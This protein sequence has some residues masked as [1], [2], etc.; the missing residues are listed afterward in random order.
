VL[1]H[2]RRG[3]RAKRQAR[4][5]PAVVLWL[6]GLAAG[7]A[8]LIGLAHLHGDPPAKNGDFPDP[9]LATLA[10]TGV[11]LFAACG[12]IVFMTWCIRGIRLEFLSWWPGR[13]V[14]HTFEADDQEVPAPE[15]ERL[16]AGFRDR[17]GMSHLQTPAPT[18]VARV[19]VPVVDRHL[20]H[21]TPRPGLVRD[22]RSTVRTSLSPFSWVRRRSHSS[23]QRRAVARRSASV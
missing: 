6:L 9:A 16:T 2:L 3:S 12:L 14:V 15:R 19:P 22:Q 13:I 17:L 5:W 4:R 23:S 1:R 11:A 18:L 8:A 7:A 21:E 20:T 10:E